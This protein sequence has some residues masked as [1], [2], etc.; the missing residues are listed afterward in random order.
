M[1]TRAFSF[2]VIALAGLFASAGAGLT[3]AQSQLFETRA[4]QAVMIDAETGTILYSKDADKL[5]PPASLAKLMTMEVVFHA[6]KVG[7]LSMEDKFA[8]SENAW[9]KGGAKSGG[10]TMFAK[11]KSQI[12]VEDL[13]QGVIVQSANDACITL[14]EGLAGTEENFATLMTERARQIGLTK[15]VFKNSNGLPAEGQV[16]T[17]RELA[18]LGRHIWKE[19][20]EYYHFYGQ[21]E[22]T[23]N[24]ITQP[25]RNPLL[26]MEIGADGMKT[27]Y[28]DASGYAIVGSVARGDNRVFAA[29][30]GMTGE[31][32]RAEESRKLLEW[33]L[34][35]F[36]RTEL[37]AA[38]E[39]IGEAQ[40][41]GGEKSGVALKAKGPISIFI[42]LT[43]TDR[44]VARIVYQGPLTAPVKEGTPVGVLRI[45]IGDNMSQETPLYAAETVGL[46]TLQQRAL[47]AMGELMVGW[48]R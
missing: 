7:R 21:R 27:G 15:S 2:I 18:M 8:V 40:V 22:F 26:E 23:W 32:E 35:A 34:R 36:E 1:A 46:G 6:L 17:M 44:L 24:K 47:D 11:L 37:F 9:K 12:R 45:W 48:L 4:K 38:E 14:A 28:T 19:Y 30:S 33:G 41:F 10:S 16:V 39:V 29:M 20:P 13:I 43:N 31:L 25:N 5:I 3:Q 42:P